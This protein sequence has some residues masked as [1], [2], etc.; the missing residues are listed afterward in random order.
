MLV[1]AILLAACVAAA[2]TAA[3]GARDEEILYW[4][5]GTAEFTYPPPTPGAGPGTMAAVRFRAPAWARSLVGVQFYSMNDQVVNPDDPTLPTTEPFVVWVW[6]PDQDLLPGVPANGGY[7]PFDGTG[8]YQEDT[9]IEVRFPTPVDISDPSHFPDGW[10]FVGVEW[11]YRM[12]PLFGLDTDPPA[13]G[14]SFGWLSTVW[15]PF[16]NDFLIRAIVSSEW[17]PID[18]SSW[19]YIKSLFQD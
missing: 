17:S 3:G 6:R 12:S 11:L 16:E 13:Y 9:W 5:D 15:E 18:A 2:G 14:H 1:S 10:F 7:Q 8:E 4:D 19:T